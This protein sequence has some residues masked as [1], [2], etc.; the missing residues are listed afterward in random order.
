VVVENLK[1]RKKTLSKITVLPVIVQRRINEK[2]FEA[3]PVILELA[4]EKFDVRM[5]IMMRRR[6]YRVNSEW[7]AQHKIVGRDHG[8]GCDYCLALSRYVADKI[9]EHRLRR[10]MDNWWYE[11]YSHCD[12]QEALRLARE[13][14]KGHKATKDYIKKEV[15]L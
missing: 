8:C 9:N 11:P 4:L 1:K 6:M 14:W 7:H 2:I 3:N 15:G 13:R 10:R 12:D 5:Q